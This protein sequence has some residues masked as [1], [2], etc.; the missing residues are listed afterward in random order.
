MLVRRFQVTLEVRL[1]ATNGFITAAR[2]L[3]LK[4][5]LLEKHSL[6]KEG[7]SWHCAKVNVGDF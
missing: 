6:P 2:F 3:G 5:G 4:L 7:V 1:S